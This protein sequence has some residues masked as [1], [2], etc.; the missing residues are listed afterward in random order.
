MRSY[1][2][3]L[4]SVQLAGVVDQIEEC[5]VDLANVVEQGNTFHHVARVFVDTHCIGQHQRVT[6]HAPY[7]SSGYRVVCVD[8]VEQRLERGSSQPLESVGVTM[9]AKR[10]ERCRCG[11]R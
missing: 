9:V 11:S 4:A 8:G 7:V 5:L 3:P 2:K 10:V 1:L 6:S